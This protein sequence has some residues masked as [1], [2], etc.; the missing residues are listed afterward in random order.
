[1]FQQLIANLFQNQNDS[2]EHFTDSRDTSPVPSEFSEI[3]R[4][5]SEFLCSN[6][7]VGSYVDSDVLSVTS[8]PSSDRSLRSSTKSARTRCV[9]S[10]Q[11]RPRKRN[12]A[13][14]SPSSNKRKK[15][16]EEETTATHP[17]HSQVIDNS[18]P[19]TE[20]RARRRKKQTPVK[21]LSPPRNS[22]VNIFSR[23]V[24][25]EAVASPLLS[26]PADLTAASSVRKSP[27]LSLLPAKSADRNSKL[28]QIKNKFFDFCRSIKSD[29][30][31]WLIK[32][33]LNLSGK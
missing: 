21:V 32:A 6:S 5:S 11:Q 2:G 9:L 20:S 1:M 4:E 12:A 33:N 15:L 30:P 18:G 16:N 19:I 17:Q 27:R 28:V 13:A 29:I 24:K 14:P 10:K 26:N 25:Y 8:E 22:Q 31:V 7:D 23:G 3:S